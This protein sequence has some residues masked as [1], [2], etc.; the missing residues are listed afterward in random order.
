MKRPSLRLLSWVAIGVGVAAAFAWAV[1]PRPLGVDVG[2]IERGTLEV[3]VEDE[4][5]TRI[6]DVYVVSA[7]TTGRML[8][9]DLTVGDAVAAGKTVVARF[10][11]SDPTLLDVRSRRVG[12]A[13]VEAAAAAVGLAEAQLAQARSQLDFARAD[14]VRA[15]ELAARRT[16]SERALDKARL[17]VATAEAT[18]KGGEATLEVRRRELEQARAQLLEPGAGAARR[19]DC[20]IS[21]PAPVDGRVLRLV[22]ESEQVVQAGNP[23]VE[24]G[25]PN[26]LEIAV[27]L[28]SRDAVRVQPGAEARIESWG[29][30]EMLTAR[31]R[32]VEPTGFTK[33]SALGIEEQR[34][35]VILDPEGPREA[36]ARLGHGYRVVVRITVKRV[37]NVPL[38]PIGALFRSGEAWAVFRAEG[39]RARLTRLEI[40]DRNQR[41]AVAT[42]G[43]EPGARVILHPSGDLVDGAR[44]AP[45]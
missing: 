22:V 30:A 14:L 20:C 21:I 6:R 34:V 44:I 41:F 33:V 27:D 32:R 9:S 24:I 28:L 25:D 15:T 29:G 7:P 19:P 5:V 26:D 3:T 39:D 1:A 2:A 8:R 16:I 45:R 43:L 23:L 40:G 18:V 42:A 31:V 36:W 35:K 37:E 38:V 13:T 12:E 11:P 17:D 4:G 10:E